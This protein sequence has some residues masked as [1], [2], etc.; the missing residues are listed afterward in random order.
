MHDPALHLFIDDHHVRTVFGLRREFGKLDKLPAPVL[1]DIPGRRA[2]WACVLREPDGLYRMWYQSVANAGAHELAK[3]GVWGRGAEFGYFLERHPEAVRETQTSVISYAESD[4]G[5]H[6]RKPDLGLIEW[7]GSTANNIVLDGVAAA[8]HY[9]NTL[10]NMDTVS[11]VR[12]GDEPDPAKRY[13][14]ICHWETIHVH[15][16][17]PTL[18]D[19]GRSEEYLQRCRASRAKYLNTSPD[20]IHWERHTP[21]ALPLF[22]DTQNIMFYDRCLGKHVA[23]VR[24]SS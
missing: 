10:T 8:K 4:D 14:M 9:A 11:V 5:I 20:G 3:A 21:C 15:D 7:Q 23:Y 17:H 6:W 13:K 19:L 22:H 18:S 2:C 1:E 12:D 16:N 24:W